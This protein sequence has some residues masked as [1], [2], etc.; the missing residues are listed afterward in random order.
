[1]PVTTAVTVGTTETGIDRD[2]VDPA[3]KPG[4]EVSR[5]EI[6]SLASHAGHYVKKLWSGQARNDLCVPQYF[7]QPNVAAPL[8]PAILLDRDI[9]SS[10][11]IICTCLA[12]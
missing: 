11:L 5:I 2:L 3:T 9:D 8:P 7:L 6:E 12:L 10:N 1:M 4:L